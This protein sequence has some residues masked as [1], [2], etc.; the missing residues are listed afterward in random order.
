MALCIGFL[1]YLVW[2]LE[3]AGQNFGVTLTQTASSDTLN[4]LRTNVNTGFTNINATILGTMGATTTSNTWAGTQT[5]STIVATNGTIT[6]TTLT[7]ASTT[8]MDIATYFKIGTNG[9]RTATDLYGSC[10]IWAPSQTIVATSTQQ[11]VCQSATNGTLSSITG[12][13]TDSVCQVVMASSTN[14]TYGGIDIQGASASST[15]GTIVL[16]IANFTGDTFTWT[17]AASSSSKWNYLC[18]DPL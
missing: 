15:A 5:L 14:T 2:G 8:A 18:K 11:A 12:I 4:T 13:T 1:G 9:T 7:Y 10:T 3:S 16:R 17:A 6:N